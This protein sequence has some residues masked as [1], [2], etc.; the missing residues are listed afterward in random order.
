MTQLPFRYSIR[1]LVR[2]KTRTAL[3][4]TG[5]ALVV[6][7]VVFMAAFSRSLAA[8]F[9]ETG[10]PD[11]MIIISKK[12]QTCVLSSIS[13]KDCDLIR[14]KLYEEAKEFVRTEEWGTLNEPLISSEVYIGLNVDVIGG[15]AFRKGRQRGNVHGVDPQ[16]AI[17]ANSHVRLLEGRLPRQDRQ[18]LAVGGMAATRIGV[19]DEDLSVGRKLRFL[20]TDWTGVGRSDAPGTIME[21]EIWAH[22]EDLRLYLKRQDYSFMR[23]K[24]KDPQK[25]A[26]LCKM[27]STD[28]QFQVKA[29]PEQEY[30][31]DFAE[32]FD[33]FRQFAHAMA[34][35]ILIGG[36]VAGMNT[37]YTS[38]M[39]RVREIGTLQVIGF[40]K[41][42]VLS[43]IMTE[44]I[45]ISL[46]GGFLGSI[47]G[48]L[49]N[50][51]PMKIPMAAFRVRVDWPV[52]AWALAAA[53]FIGTCG[54]LVPACRA[55][56][57]R[58]VDAIRY[59]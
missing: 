19:S 17:A 20:G 14:S 7:A 39:G 47:L 58:M 2:R 31:A 15:Q 34:L 49:A 13:E 12:A 54:A 38:V 45:L 22:V 51:L 25:M 48:T 8:T 28:E 32:G 42:S 5:L 52:F 44:S 33:Y 27:L 10:D 57:L 35:I 11:N 6:A 56:R 36:V 16:T 3:T 40:S 21:S 43:G 37:M 55:L 41:T 18:E 30:F 23:V 9:R 4:I 46:A 26:E 24:L 59:Q 50:G 1:N 53:F 29:F